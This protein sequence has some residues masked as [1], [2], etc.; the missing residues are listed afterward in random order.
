MKKFALLSLFTVA[1]CAKSYVVN[2]D[3]NRTII[4]YDSA[5]G[6]SYDD[7]LNLSLAKSTVQKWDEKMPKPLS[8]YHY[9]EDYLF[10]GIQFD[11]TLEKQRRAKIH[12]F[13][14]DNKDNPSYPFLKQR[15]DQAKEKLATIQ[16]DPFPSFLKFLDYIKDKDVHL[17]FRTYGH[18]F[19][20]LGID[21]GEP[22]A[23]AHFEKGVLHLNGKT[24]HTPDEQLKAYK[25][26]KFMHVQDDHKYWLSHDES[27]DFGKPFAVVNNNDCLSLFFDDNVV[28]S[29]DPNRSIVCPSESTNKALMEAG[30]LFSVDPIEAILDDNYFIDRFHLLENMTAN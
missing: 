18:D 28:R 14:E 26:Y 13:L 24:Y 7:L 27:K 5:R 19:D 22:V 15:Y 17:V 25:Q 29:S 16:N 11:H 10:P 30:Q 1:L 6:Y 2:M 21:F 23:K 12:S 8:Y 9:V 20:N 3:V 4:A